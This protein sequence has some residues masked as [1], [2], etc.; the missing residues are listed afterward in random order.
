MYKLPVIKGNYRPSALLKLPLVVSIS[1]LPYIN[2]SQYYHCMHRYFLTWCDTRKLEDD[3]GAKMD[4]ELK[5]E[6]RVQLS[7][8]AKVEMHTVL[9][10]LGQG[11]VEVKNDEKKKTS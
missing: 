10:L 8:S 6:A 5:L 11:S 9:S 3:E 1:I 7:G 2:L 4:I